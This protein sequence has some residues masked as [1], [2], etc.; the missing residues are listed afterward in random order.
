MV[1]IILIIII[2]KILIKKNKNKMII[3]SR[4]QQTKK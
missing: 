4:V 1:A 3:K 2:T